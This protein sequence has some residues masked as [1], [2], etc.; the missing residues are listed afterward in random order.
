MFTNFSQAINKFYTNE[1][2]VVDSTNLHFASSEESNKQNE[3]FNTNPQ[4]S[5]LNS[6]VSRKHQNKIMKCINRTALIKVM[7][8]LFEFLFTKALHIVGHLSPHA[9][10]SKFMLTFC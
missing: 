3:L 10:S 6:K 8:H 5:Y 9:R 2:K 7:I 4:L 1:F